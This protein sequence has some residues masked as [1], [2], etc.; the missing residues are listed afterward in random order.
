[1]DAPLGAGVPGGQVLEP[2]I[3]AATAAA[4]SSSGWPVASALTSA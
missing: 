1:L 3:S 4:S 2:A